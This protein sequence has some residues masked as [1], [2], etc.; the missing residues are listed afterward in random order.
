MKNRIAHLFKLLMLVAFIATSIASC[1][2]LDEKLLGS[3]SEYKSDGGASTAELQ[4]VYQELNG[5][6][7]EGNINGMNMHTTDELCGPTRGTDWDD[8]GTWR[9]LHLHTWT[10]AH[11]QVF[12]AWNNL[13]RAFFKATLV[14]EGSSGGDKAQAQFLRALFGWK[15]MDMYGQL[16][17]RSASAGPDDIPTVKSRTEAVDFVLADLDAA[18]AGLSDYSGA[19]SDKNLAT[20]QG[21]QFLKMKVLL[22]KG[23][24]TQS[25]SSPA[26]PFTH[27]AAD[28]NEVIALADEITASSQFHISANYWDNFKWDNGSKSSEIIFSRFNGSG[29]IDVVWATCMGFHYKQTPGGWNG[30][31]TLADFYDSFE[32]GD[33]RK[34]ADIPGFTELV[35]YNAGF[36]VGQQKGPEG[37][38]VGNPLVDLKD[39]SGGPLVFTR[40]V[41]LFYST[42][43][44]GIRTVKYPLDPS[45]INDGGWGSKNEYVFFRYADV[46]L[47]KAEAIL[48]GGSATG[49]DSPLSLVNSIRQ[50]RNVA[51]LGSIDLTVLLAER[52][53]ELYLEGWRRN[54]LIRF[55]KFNDPVGERPYKSDASRVI[56]PIPYQALSTNPNLQQNFGY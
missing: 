10:D 53:R 51:D 31:T 28:M 43:S 17:F 24:Y 18:I 29:G 6:V 39:R 40:D 22:N 1:S 41:S 12:N 27:S 47:M 49:G 11:D 26:G 2:K 50:D 38:H 9:K 30:F 19:P 45:T 44:K 14:V 25:P 42:E 20:K 7:G 52:G 8:F 21:A 15:I 32:D 46:L 13:N 33:V 54:D 55:E 4:S 5:L 35:G 23:V 37:Q 3:K 34:K 56:F 36:L 48:R 16:P